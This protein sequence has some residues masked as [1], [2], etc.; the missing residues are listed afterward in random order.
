M[1]F[2]PFVTML[3]LSAPELR[4]LRRYSDNLELALS[5]SN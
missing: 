1:S 3:F 2:A 4:E 5:E